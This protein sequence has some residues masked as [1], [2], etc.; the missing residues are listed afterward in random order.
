[1]SRDLC[2]SYSFSFQLKT[3][4]DIQYYRKTIPKNDLKLLV[5]KFILDFIKDPKSLTNK[6][7]KRGT[8]GKDRKIEDDDKF[9]DFTFSFKKSTILKIRAYKKKHD[10]HNLD[11]NVEAYIHLVVPTREIR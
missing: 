4:Q 2:A 8:P 3:C 9:T 6:I 10:M 7:I 5:E 1:M 11:R